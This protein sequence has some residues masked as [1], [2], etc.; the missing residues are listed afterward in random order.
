MLSVKSPKAS[1]ADRARDTRRRMLE[2]ARELFLA[3]GYPA[4]TME[5]IASAAGVAVQ[6]TYYTFRTKG[7]LLCEV[8]QFASADEDEPLPVAQR[9]W[10]REAR[11][12]PS[13][14]RALA[15]AVEHGADI[16]ERAAQLWPSVNAAATLDH[17]VEQYWR[18]VAADRRAGQG[19]LVARLAELGALRNGLTP[20]RATDLLVVLFGHEVFSG[21]A[22]AGWTVSAYKA[23]LFT[24]L[25]QQLLLADRLEPAAVHDLS[26]GASV[27]GR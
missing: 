22:E 13:P 27:F 3:Q 24:T 14:Q 11:S 17:D 2:S 16:F 15:L 12:A 19:R 4:T 20:E 8:V 6:T 25:V 26:F 23:W 21:L 9:P 10:M 1:R 18:G 7:R 5:Q